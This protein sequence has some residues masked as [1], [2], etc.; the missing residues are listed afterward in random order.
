MIIYAGNA[1]YYLHALKYSAADPES[2]TSVVIMYQTSQIYNL[3]M[4][5][6]RSACIGYMV[7]VALLTDRF[8]RSFRSFVRT[9]ACM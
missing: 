6:F 1:Q 2:S 7:K 3:K 4:V 5:Y 8:V 9:Y